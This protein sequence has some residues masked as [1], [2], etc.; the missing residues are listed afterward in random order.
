MR[1][2][3]PIATIFLA[4]AIVAALTYGVRWLRIDASVEAMRVDDDPD[5]TFFEEMKKV[6][7]NDEL[8]LVGVR[9]G[10]A[11]AARSLQELRALTD[12]LEMLPHVLDVQSLSTVD[13]PVSI[14]GVLSVRPLVPPVIDDQA[15]EW[16]RH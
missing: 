4:V 5:Q 16:V 14:D 11:L 13:D 10:D 6:F 7:G 1:N 2:S 15:S 9:S 8:M 3:F 12:Q